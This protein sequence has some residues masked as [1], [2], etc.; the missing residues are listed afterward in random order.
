[1][2]DQDGS[3]RKKRFSRAWRTG[4]IVVAM[5][6]GVYD[7]GLRYV[8][9]WWMHRE[10]DSWNLSHPDWKLSLPS[11][12][13]SPWRWSVH[14][15]GMSLAQQHRPQL[16][17]D[18]LYLKLS[19]SSLWHRALIIQDIS[20]EHPRIQVHVDEHG[21][22]DLENLLPP[23][24]PATTAKNAPGIGWLIRNLQVAS[25]QVHIVDAQIQGG[26]PLDLKIPS[27]QV[28][29]VGTWH[30]H[31]EIQLDMKGA[32]GGAHAWRLRWW[33]SLNLAP[34]RSSGHIMLTQGNLAALGGA[35]QQLWPVH[36]GQGTLEFSTNYAFDDRH[37][38]RQW[39]LDHTRV[40]VQGL[41]VQ[42]PGFNSPRLELATGDIQIP[43][44]DGEQHQIEVQSVDLDRP[45]LFMQRDVQGK[46]D[47]LTWIKELAPPHPSPKPSPWQVKA[48]HVKLRR[49]LLTLH[50][51]EAGKERAFMLQDIQ[52]DLD[53][54]DT[55]GKVPWTLQAGMQGPLLGQVHVQGQVAAG[56][57]DVNWQIQRL[58]LSNAD[59]WLP[60]VL[61][62]KVHDGIL[63][64]SGHVSLNP[65]HLESLSLSGQ[66]AIE[67][68]DMEIQRQRLQVAM[69]QLD[70]WSYQQGHVALQGLSVHAL[71]MEQ[72]G[73]M[74]SLGDAE[75]GAVHSPV[76]GTIWTLGRFSLHNLGWQASHVGPVTLQGHVKALGI[77]AV[78]M[79]MHHGRLG[80][81]LGQLGGGQVDLLHGKHHNRLSWSQAVLDRGSW[82]TSNQKLDIAGIHARQWRWEGR[83]PWL[84]LH[85]LDG[86]ELHV[87]LAKHRLRSG[88]IALQLGQLRLDQD[89]HGSLVPYQEIQYW[90]GKLPTTAST[91]H[92]TASVPWS[93]D[94]QGFHLGMDRLRY[95]TSTTSVPWVAT[96]LAL[97]TGRLHNLNPLS[98]HMSGQWGQAQLAWN[99]TVWPQL[100]KARGQF[101]LRDID[102]MP[103]QPWLRQY[104]YAVLDHGTI[105]SQGYVAF[106]LKPLQVV[107]HGSLTTGDLL[108]E[109][110]RNQQP[111][112][113]W[114]QINIPNLN[115]SYPGHGLSIPE[116][117]VDHLYS[118]VTIE[119][120]G[121][122]NWQQILRSRHQAAQPPSKHP[123]AVD[124]HRIVF[125]QAGVDFSDLSLHAPFH[126]SIHHLNGEVGPLDMQNTSAWTQVMMQGLIN[127][128]GHVDVSGKVKPFAK[129]AAVDA[130]LHFRDIEMP[131]LNPYAAQFAGYRID[132]GMM[133]LEL[134]YRLDHQHLIGSN[135]L[136]IDQLELGP[137]LPGE[138]SIDLPLRL[139]V[140]VLRNS[141]GRIDLSVPVY[142]N[143]ND[144]NLDIRSVVVKAL[145]GT[146]RH[147]LD[148]PLE[149]VAELW[150]EHSDTIKHVDFM[151]GSNLISDQEQAKLSALV[152]VLQQH[153]HL[154][155]F[156]HAGFNSVLDAQVL[157]TGATASGSLPA[158]SHDALRLLALHRAEAIK[159]QLM[160]AGIAD[161][162]IFI[163]EPQSVNAISGA[164]IPTTLDIKLR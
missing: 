149:F 75:V 110:D 55:T 25:L 155:L 121:Q 141:E 40:Q 146:L 36:I 157:N 16:S 131:T 106:G 72:D 84:D 142:G 160:K 60:P 26:K 68:L 56:R 23:P 73:D 132:Q 71:S 89:R 133:D 120:N 99:G 154:L 114:K 113:S 79:D 119:S 9:P 92:K 88:K 112:L 125:D 85:R 150:G 151:A 139:A 34:L 91:P 97:D 46:V 24:Q 117:D 10:A 101:K 57:A 116:V 100:K 158:L 7:V 90:L 45:E 39:T 153:V 123:L 59:L 35:L 78:R 5:L 115:V 42:R 48:Q 6:A 54:L 1:M 30:A 159:S 138:A 37:G 163:D 136:R 148:S 65:Q 81:Q 13:I 126:A 122:L 118:K 69:L 67:H 53:N 31:T 2:H 62:T 96:Q 11:L 95:A 105:S 107:L 128:H 144:P 94:V 41:R 143:L 98:V 137:K 76:Q 18:E 49:G 127:R 66:A 129:T 52:L 108:L 32:L 77:Q 20:I 19:P 86:Y 63:T 134:N 82:Q 140:D 28:Q 104:T 61:N 103:V 22:L 164:R 4:G 102:L 17:I 83:H 130:S 44:I 74:L 145:E 50:A 147:V 162:R 47:F 38:H 29:D 51:W 80:W 64:A 21:H 109:D 87:Q 70:P 161:H 111:L 15:Q 14:V 8:L 93:I 3:R 124:V 156:I 43:H 12:R 135:R 152:H 33:G 27:W 58:H